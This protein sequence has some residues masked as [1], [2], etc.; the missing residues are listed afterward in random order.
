M[1]NSFDGHTIEPLLNQME[2]NK[3]E[4]PEELVYDRGSKGKSEIKVVKIIIPSSPKNTDTQYE[5]QEKR[6][7]CRARADNWSFKS[8]FSDATELSFRE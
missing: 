2:I 8:Q 1:E 4:L 6:K 7:K 5:R 3:I